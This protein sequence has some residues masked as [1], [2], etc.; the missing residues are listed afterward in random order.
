MKKFLALLLAIC[1]AAVSFGCSGNNSAAGSDDSL[2]KITESGKLVLGLDD[3]FPPMGYR[4]ADTNEI[5]GYD[6]DLAKEVAK[7]MGVEL[8]LTPIDWDFKETELNDGNIDCIWNGMSIDDDRK[9]K[10][11]LSEPYMENRQVVVVLSDSGINDFAGLAGKDVLLQEG[12]TAVGALDS[13]EEVKSTLNSV[14]EVNDN[15][16]AMME[17]GQ[18]TGHAVVMDEVVARYY[19]SKS[20]DPDAFK[21][22]DETLADE[23]YAI[24]FRK[25]DSA[26]R[27][28]VQKILGEMKA[29]GT[30]KTITEAWFGKDTSVVPDNK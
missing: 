17:L 27:N 11:N 2:K 12:S 16:Q 20:D 14:T 29:D 28:E 22:L 15:V 7:R 6:I 3:S 19:I 13:N 18:G 5:V 26:L 23:V 10:M 24:G 1:L 25:N 30:L 21:V 9:E 8:V 4:D